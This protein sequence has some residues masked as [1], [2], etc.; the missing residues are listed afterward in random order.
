MTR[1]RAP[2]PARALALPALGAALACSTAA[3]PDAS[4]KCAEDTPCERDQEC[5][6]G[7]C[8][9]SLLP[10]RAAIALDVRNDGF[11]ATPA[12]VEILGDDA[13]V[14]RLLDRKPNRH[15]VG[16]T[17]SGDF[18]GIRDRLEITLEEL[19]TDPPPGELPTAMLAADIELQQASRIGRA[20]LRS[21]GLA[22]PVLDP[23]TSQPAPEPQVV[24][25]WPR[26]DPQD[27]GGDLPLYVQI[28]PKADPDPTVGRG[29]IYRQLVRANV[30]GASRHNFA[31][32][33]VRECHRR[34][35]G[36]LLFPDGPPA[37]PPDVDPATLAIS[38]SMKHAGRADDGDTSTPIC[39]PAPVT[40]TPATCS[41]A[42]VLPQ[43]NNQ[44]ESNLQ[45]A[46]PYRCYDTP[47][48]QGK[49]CGCRLDRD[50]PQGQV[51]NVERQQCALDLTDRPAIQSLTVP[52]GNN[53]SFE[54]WTYTYCDEDPTADRRMEFVVT[55]D[56]SEALGLPRLSYTG[57]VDFVYDNGNLPLTKLK[58][59]CLP[60]WDL[61]QK[62]ELALTGPPALLY[63]D[64]Q[65]RPW[66]CCDT[67]CI[68]PDDEVPVAPDICK[69]KGSIGAT[70]AIPVTMLTNQ[71]WAESL[72]CMSPAGVDQDVVRVTYKGGECPPEG[73]TCAI[74][75]SPGPP[76][77]GGLTY[78]LR[79]EPPVGSI[80]RST[81]VELPVTKETTQ[82]AIGLPYRVL[83]RGRVTADCA[84]DTDGA[85]CSTAAEVLAERLTRNEDPTT[86]IGPYLYTTRTF[87]GG[88]YVLPVNP[89]VYL[90]T[91][92]PQIS[93]GSKIG[94]AAI[95]VVD[96]RETS[97]AVRDEDGLLV[98]DAPDLELVPGSVYTIE[99]D[100]FDASSR[101]FP[102]DLTSWLGLAFEKKELN[103]NASDTC[104]AAN[105]GCQIR[106]L[107]PGNSPA[108]LTQNQFINYVA[109]AAAD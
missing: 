2:G 22:F 15:R 11:S 24:V 102:L 108:L 61:A 3:P 67:G 31:V 32:P 16:L 57:V 73:T 21:S 26:Y 89:G 105:E 52:L 39:D 100:D 63:R 85:A 94:P 42:T 45:C 68:Q 34:L 75:L 5:I 48:G 54:A 9:Q 1:R 6:D 107:R 59:L 72:N 14:A 55:A 88:E 96:L 98:A 23:Q 106:R 71:T 46:D 27:P 70:G 4:R 44:C 58:R 29:I 78:S 86:L 99:L 40:G 38:V 87:E 101:V 19:R 83:L 81:I 90:L 36:T 69:V 65:D 79:I 12:R 104:A 97:M 35:E 7:A 41:P 74:D 43:T 53:V 93:A 10:P 50:C 62:I 47:N 64:A 60:T 92:L 37:T 91:A 109:R 80:F 56:P 13:A 8:Y 30:G 82:K 51:C 95:T 20:P 76:D 77:G 33:S 17:D 66:V 18:P 84:G 28:S 49:R 103:L 25:P